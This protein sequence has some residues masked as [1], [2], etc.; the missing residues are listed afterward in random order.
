MEPGR[1]SPKTFL[2][3]VLLLAELDECLSDSKTSSLAL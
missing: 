2:S 3:D 1:L